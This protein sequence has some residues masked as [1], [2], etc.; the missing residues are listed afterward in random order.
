M[1][2]VMTNGNDQSTRTTAT[3][4]TVNGTSIKLDEFDE[5][6][7]QLNSSNSATVTLE[8]AP[9]LQKVVLEDISAEEYYKEHTEET[10]CKIYRFQILNE[11]L[12]TMIDNSILDTSTAKPYRYLTGNFIRVFEKHVEAFEKMKV[13]IQKR[14][15]IVYEES[16]RNNTVYMRI[17]G[18]CKLCPKSNRVKY[19]FTVKAKPAD[20]DKY[21]EVE[22][23]CRGLHNH[24]NHNGSMLNGAGS[25]NQ[26]TPAK[27]SRLS[28]PNNLNSSVQHA[29]TN[30]GN[31][32]RVVL[33][34]KKRK[35]EEDYAN[36]SGSNNNGGG[37][38][39]PSSNKLSTADKNMLNQVVNQISSKIMIK[40]DQINLK[41]N[42][43]SDRLF[44]LERKFETIEVAEII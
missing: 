26:S 10:T 2:I 36:T 9:K 22:T 4:V 20:T 38:S 18:D 34:T 41:L 31:N 7:A 40:L 43:I 32:E 21:V 23:K 24:G 33:L 17:N 16:A 8:T 28:L 3:L 1:E 25:S 6:Q 35:Y 44:D 15:N 13:P 42:Q 11:E 29:N 5:S 37:L 19:V 30:G 14:N 39:P 27:A 12:K